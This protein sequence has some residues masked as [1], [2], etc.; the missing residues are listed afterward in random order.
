MTK[1]AVHLLLTSLDRSPCVVAFEPE[2]A[3][4]EIPAAGHFKV[5]LSGPGDGVV[6]VSWDPT[7]LSVA[8]WDGATVE[9]TDQ[10]GR[11]LNI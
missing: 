2:G 4:H 5:S 10:D 9:V 11:R 3:T 8:G 1:N 6:E 7:G